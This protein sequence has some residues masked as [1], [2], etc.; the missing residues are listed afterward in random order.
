[1]RDLI[2]ILGEIKNARIPKGSCSPKCSILQISNIHT[3]STYT[4]TMH[5]WDPLDLSYV[6]EHKYLRRCMVEQKT[7]VAYPCMCQSQGKLGFLAKKL[8]QWPKSS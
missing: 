1:M 6:N 5:A 2:K 3:K 8:K 7:S 4:Y